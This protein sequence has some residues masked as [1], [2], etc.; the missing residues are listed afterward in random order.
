MIELTLKS[1]IT[2]RTI[3]SSYTAR[4]LLD[5]DEESIVCEL[6]ECNC[7]PVGETNLVECKCDEEWDDYTLVIGSD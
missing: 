6:T 7:Q 5:K 4:Q 3:K 2:N 1:N